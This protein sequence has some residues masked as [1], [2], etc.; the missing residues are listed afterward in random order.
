MQPHSPPRARRK[1][2]FGIYAVLV[3]TL[4]VAWT[5][6]ARL[7]AELAHGEDSAPWTVL[8]RAAFERGDHAA[9]LRLAEAARRA[10]RPVPD[11]LEAA[12]LIE[13][14]RGEEAR[15]RWPEGPRGRGELAR[16]VAAYLAAWHD[17][18]A[19][20][21]Y[22]R[23]GR[24]IGHVRGDGEL[25]LADG[26]RA[27]WIPRSVPELAA[28]TAKGSLRL[29][30]DL[31]LS[32]LAFEAF[33]RWYRGSIVLLD[34]STGEILAAVS[35]RRT[36]AEDEDGTP[37]FDQMREP[38]S[39]SKLITTT[40]YL[41]AGRD[42]DA[43]LG[44][45]RCTGSG[46]YSGK[47]LYCPHVGGPLRGLDKALAI[48]CNMAFANLGVELG[49]ARMLEE[50]HRYGFADA[51]ARQATARIVQARG[52]DRQLADLS[53]GLE[54]TDIT[55]LHAAL[56]AAAMVDGVLPEPTLLN[57]EDGRLGYHPRPVEPHPGKRILEP[58]WLPMLHSAMETVA[59]SGT[60]RNIA[61][62]SLPV[63]MKTGTAS[64]P[65]YGF[66]TNYIGFGPTVG[67]AQQIAFAVRLTDQR[68]SAK[69]RSASRWVTSRLL[70]SLALAT[71]FDTAPPA[72]GDAAL[73]ADAA[74]DRRPPPPVLEPIW[75]SR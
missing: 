36:F 18:G 34:P 62:P 44:H 51:R 2:R 59:R 57:A 54:A 24:S 35:D 21:L 66:H 17:D 31:E 69:V 27:E 71:S 26:V 13:L 50:L 32:R 72:L 38:A 6:D 14:G 30:L 28:A 67:D 56:L 70:R 68:T 37:A 12:A 8:A 22:D 15:R 1:A 41:R 49:R 29:S 65:R 46:L 39:I 25:A 45:T 73:L 60:A 11:V 23:T 61:P 19:V 40:A 16:R 64:H 42:P 74:S 7:N 63:A 9:A 48:S 33:G 75:L 3:A 52:D 53:V 47:Y 20:F 5:L 4:A 55:P 43:E 58:A 10:G